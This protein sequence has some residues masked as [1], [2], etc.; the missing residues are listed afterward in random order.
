M[1][2]A[3][4]TRHFAPIAILVKHA[5]AHGEHAIDH[6]DVNILARPGALRP[7]YRRHD[8]ER[9][10]DR[11]DRIPNPGA[12]LGGGASIGPGDGHDAA[13][14]LRDHVIGGPVHIRACPGLRVAEATDR[15]IDD[16][17]VALPQ[18]RVAKSQPLHDASAKILN[19]D[20]RSV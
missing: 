10:H 17:R 11:R 15:G 8:A 9:G 13:H 20:L 14:G 5:L 6:A 2:I 12:Y 19:D 4:R 18:P 3:F 7:P 1:T 16:A